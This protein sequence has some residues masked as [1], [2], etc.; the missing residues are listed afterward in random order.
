M[1]PD[2]R[3]EVYPHAF[4]RDLICFRCAEVAASLTVDSESGG[5]GMTLTR[6][7]FLARKASYL[8]EPAAMAIFDAEGPEL[9]RWLPQTFWGFFCHECEAP[10]CTSCWTLFPPASA[11]GEYLGR[12]GRCPIGHESLVDS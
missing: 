11:D 4:R 8:S 3:S 12:A 6:T 7:G 9:L 5:R 2:Q 1:E 10:Y